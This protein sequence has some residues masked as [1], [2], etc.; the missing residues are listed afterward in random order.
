MCQINPVQVA[1]AQE[2]EEVRQLRQELSSGALSLP[3]AGPAKV[4]LRD[5]QTEAVRQL[6]ERLRLG[7]V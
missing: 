2:S 6:M 4:V 7:Q 5:P 1:Y 3:P